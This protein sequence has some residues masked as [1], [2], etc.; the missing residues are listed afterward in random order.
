M[1]LLLLELCVTKDRVPLR[2]LA[3]A[4]PR[5]VVAHKTA[6]S[7]RSTERGRSFC[8]QGSGMGVVVGQQF[9]QAAGG[10]DGEVGAGRV[11]HPAF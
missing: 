10:L 1:F 6:P 2:G 5:I 11:F 8:S 4:G 3:K 9:Q 7:P